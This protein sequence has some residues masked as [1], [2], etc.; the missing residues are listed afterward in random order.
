MKKYITKVKIQDSTLRD[1][2]HAV[3]HQLSIENIEQYCQAA[4][5]AGIPIIEVGHGNGLGGSSL[6]VGFSRVSDIDTIKTARDNLS[7]SKLAVLMI[8]GFATIKRDLEQAISM[9][10]DVVRVGCHCTEADI[11]KRHIEYATKRGVEVVGSLMMSH[12]VTKEVLLE[13]AKKIQDYGATGVSLYDSAGAYLPF[14]VVE[15][16]RH[17]VKNLDIEIGF[18][19]HNNLGMAV[20]NSVAAVES[21]AS[22][23]DGCIAGFGAGSGNAQLEALVAVLSKMKIQTGIDLYGVLDCA[24]LALST[25]IEEA[26]FVKTTG[27]V[28]GL[29]GVF[30][31]FVK[32]VERISRQYDVDPRD[33]FF[34]L[35]ERNV[36]AGQED[37]IIEVAANLKGNNDKRKLST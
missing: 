13:E 30:S 26:P 32:H 5:N 33:V 25:F 27:I 24:D 6:Q 36:V 29:A 37:L 7:N 21:G 15:K 14:E 2:N 11:T 12:S 34:E 17:L 18:H 10:V 31:G 8:P 22:I 35:G 3:R 23:V 20:A 19:A 28:S 4:D 1:G 16:I 9:G